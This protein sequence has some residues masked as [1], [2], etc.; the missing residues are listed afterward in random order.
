MN[1]SAV[2]ADASPRLISLDAYRGFVMICLA[3]NGFGIAA[4]AAKKEFLDSP[5]WQSL[6]FQ[7]EHVP[8]TGCAFW[9]LIQPS[10]MFMVGVSMPYSYCKRREA[11][12]SYS[13]LL[14][15]AVL[16]SII[17]V[18]LGIFLSSSGKTTNFTFMNVLSQIGL[19]YTFLFL[20]WDREPKVQ[21]RIATGILLAYWALFAFS[22][23][24]KPD[25][26]Y[27]KVG[28]PA[29]WP[30]LTGFAA[31]WQKC[32]NVA[33]SFDL[34]FLNLFPRSEVFVANN[35]GYQTLNFVP[36]LVTMLF[37]LM[38]GEF[39]RRSTDRRKALLGLISAGVLLLGIGWGCE[40][41]GLSAGE[42]DLDPQLDSV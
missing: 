18:L 37:G 41:L 4:T 35:G 23:V 11:G 12:D 3:A 30:Y 21:L 8:W 24:A 42:A 13:H 38:T 14:G 25:F 31:H 6:R 33:A 28:L 17:L 9:D 29:D 2:R 7:F 26:D 5:L 39:I 19:G 22:P 1:P 15:H 16:R 27:A 10:F 36:S 40:F 34:W 32:A 20:L